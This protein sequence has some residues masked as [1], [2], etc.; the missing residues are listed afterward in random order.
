MTLLGKILQVMIE[1]WHLKAQ[2]AVIR[3]YSQ[4]LPHNKLLWNSQCTV[5]TKLLVGFF[6]IDF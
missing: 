3:L 4:R 6:V 5:L 1:I 2:G